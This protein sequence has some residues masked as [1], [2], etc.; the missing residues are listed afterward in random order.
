MSTH[1]YQHSW[2]CSKPT[3]ES[4]AWSFKQACDAC[5]EQIEE[6]HGVDWKVTD[7][8]FED[9]NRKTQT[10]TNWKGER[11]WRCT[12]TVTAKYTVVRRGLAADF[13][14]SEMIEDK[15]SITYKMINVNYGIGEGA[16]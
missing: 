2:S 9:N 13:R 6:R 1:E 11:T 8:T 15:R 5:L 3:S 7:V 10:E 4:H 16:N 12:H 14:S